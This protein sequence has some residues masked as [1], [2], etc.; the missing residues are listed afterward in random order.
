M[1]ASF[2]KS[3]LPHIHE[4]Q[5]KLASVVLQLEEQIDASFSGFDR[6][7]NHSARGDPH[8]RR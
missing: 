1:N 2:E 6:Q 3:K 8:A 5:R 7:P 4:A